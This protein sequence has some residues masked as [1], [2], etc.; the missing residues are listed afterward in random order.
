MSLD[1][2]QRAIGM[3]TAGMRIKD[4]ARYFGVNSS[5]ISR[6]RS[7][8]RATGQVRDRQRTGRPR[9]TTLRQDRYLVLTSR[10]NRFMSAPKLLSRHYNMIGHRLGVLTVRNRL[11]ATSLRGRRPYVGVP[12]R[13][14]HRRNRYNWA[15]AHRRWRRQQ[16]DNILFTDESRFTLQF[17]DGRIRVWRRN[18]DRFDTANVLQRDRFGGGS[19]MVW[20]GISKNART[21][22]VTVAGTLTDVRYCQQI[23]TPYILPFMRRHNAT[24][25]QDNA[26]CHTARYSM[27]L[28]QRNNVNVFDWPA[29]SPDLSPIEH[30]WDMLGRRVR[31]RHDVHSL[32]AMALHQKWGQIPVQNVNKLMNSMRKRCGA[33]IAAAGGHTRY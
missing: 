13:A 12:L 10:R 29:R 7:R 30:M 20:G 21:D 26:R 22:L 17:S 27:D 19:I 16:W 18:G 32:A 25:H 4:V 14:V 2:R 23:V 11:R 33:V 1:R 31:E 28:L 5:T 9:R 8:F 15:A 3:I 24:L 6:L